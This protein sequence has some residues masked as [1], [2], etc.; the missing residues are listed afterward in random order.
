M[1]KIKFPLEM[2]GGKQV[3]ELDE[4]QEAFDLEKAVE[5]FSNGKL[6]KWLENNY[7]DDIL[8]ELEELTGKEEDFIQRFTHALGV[9][10]E[11]NADIKKLLKRSELKE[12]LK[13][14]VSEEELEKILPATA[15]DQETLEGL[16]E[17]G[18]RE[19]YLYAGTYLLSETAHD[20]ILHGI[21][22]PKIT[23]RSESGKE[24]RKRKVKLVDVLPA[25]EET[26][27]ILHSNVWNDAVLDLL[28]ILESAIRKG[29]K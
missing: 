29:E 15:D 5:Y 20:V 2:A 22:E 11:E 14:H 21:Q 18:C 9:D 12:K 7:N 27:N 17:D 8:E 26:E 24:F 16:L 1:K 19:I 10:Y 25:D 23:I 6:Q 28:D 3:R 13:R 4:F